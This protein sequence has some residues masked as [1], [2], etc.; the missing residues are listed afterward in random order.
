MDHNK[1]SKMKGIA[2]AIIPTYNEAANCG[3][4]C[5]ESSNKQT[6]MGIPHTLSD[7]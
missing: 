3:D 7:V 6:V 1:L 5:P 4:Y 2:C